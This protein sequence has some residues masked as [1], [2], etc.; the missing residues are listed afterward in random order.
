M[1]HRIFLSKLINNNKIDICTIDT[2]SRNKVDTMMLLNN[3][4]IFDHMIETD[5]TNK[6]TKHFIVI[7]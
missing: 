4:D 5:K 6:I 2:T 3:W 1:T 7:R